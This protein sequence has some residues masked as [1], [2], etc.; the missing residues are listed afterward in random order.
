MDQPGALLV[1]RLQFAFL[2][3]H[4]ALVRTMWRPGLRLWHALLTPMLAALVLATF[5]IVLP[6]HRDRTWFAAEWPGMLQK[7]RARI[8]AP[9]R[10]R[11]PGAGGGI[12]EK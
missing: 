10:G 12:V 6:G 1:A 8:N 7:L 2:V 9:P 4:D 11:V 3:A 5:K